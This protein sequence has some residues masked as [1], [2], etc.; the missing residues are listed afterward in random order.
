MAV[1]HDHGGL[2]RYLDHQTHQ[3]AFALR[4]IE[5]R[6]SGGE[7]RP[8][9]SYGLL[10]LAYSSYL[11]GGIRTV[12]ARRATPPLRW[13]PADIALLSVATFR[14]SR[15]VAKDSITSVVRAPFTRFE[16]QAGPDEVNE[17][18]IG[19]GP[20][21]AVG[22]LI[23][24]PFCLSIWI[25][26]TLMFGMLLFPRATRTVCTVLASVAASDCL[27]FAYSALESEG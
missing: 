7:E 8:I 12:R 1:R 13:G 21:H 16:G 22:E 15:L 19:T 2:R 3:M 4:G 11:A 23:S 5:Q 17:T 27:Q 25:A 20:R 9:G 26:T 18:V 24:C 6:Y 14:G 10:M